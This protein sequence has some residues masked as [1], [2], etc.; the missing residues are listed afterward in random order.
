MGICAVSRHRSERDFLC[1]GLRITDQSVDPKICNLDRQ[2]VAAFA[3]KRTDIQTERRVPGAAC[4]LA[5]NRHIGKLTHGAQVKPQGLPVFPAARRGE[6]L[7]IGSNTR[8]IFDPWIG[9]LVQRRETCKGGR[10]RRPATG[11][12]S[13]C[14]DTVQSADN[15]KPPTWYGERLHCS[16]LAEYN[17]DGLIRSQ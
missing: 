2:M 4:D 15:C 1:S 13:D 11:L 17:V 5:V 3:G 6:V 10:Y 8:E 14:P 16:V 7:G 12:K 9:V